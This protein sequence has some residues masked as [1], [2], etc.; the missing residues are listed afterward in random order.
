MK[1]LH[2]IS[3]TPDF[4]G[5]GKYVLEMIK[6][7]KISKNENYLV[8][9]I[10]DDF[11]LPDHV[12]S[13]ENCQFIRFGKDLNFPIVGMSDVM[14][15]SSTVC[16][17]LTPEQ[18]KQY[19]TVFLKKIR[20]AAAHFS[21]DII[22]TNHLWVA[23]AAARNA[24]PDI[25]IVT[26]C[27]GTC[28]RQHRLCPDLG[29]SLQ[30]PLSK[31]DRFIAL[32][33]EQKEDIQNLLG[34]DPDRIDVISGGF[35]PNCF[36]FE[37]KQD[38]PS[39]VQI[40]YAGKLNAS[41]GVPWL[42]KSLNM[43]S[44]D[45]FHLHL[46]GGGS[47]PEKQQCLE[48]AKPLGTKVTV[49]GILSHENLAELMRASHIF[50]LPSFFE[51]LPLVLLEAMACGCR[52]ITTGLPGSKQLFSETHPDMIS[53]I[54]LPQLMTI[55]RPHPKDEP[56]LEAQLAALLK[57]GIKEVQQGSTPD[58]EYILKITQP[59][60]WKKIF[61]RVENVYRKTA[62]LFIPQTF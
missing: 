44:T 32:F 40:L 13:S 26:S 12:L 46:V 54:K 21:P 16:S 51:G 37:K 18:V 3:Q 41:K 61:S 2:I 4:T 29:R 28:L 38:T 43:L 52:I 19:K 34:I 42:L 10:S 6:Q 49:H 27:H 57:Q 60:T 50:V 17:C 48:L 39:T 45:Q 22:H 20:Q 5:S 53:M 55:D 33:Q 7:N 11:S 24:V 15:Y 36:Y 30:N 14:P 56:E 35:N 9:G 58:Q 62:G 47:G 25:P 23:S 8:A 31:I 59:Y 1:V